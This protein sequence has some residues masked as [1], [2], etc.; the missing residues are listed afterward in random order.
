MIPKHYFRC[1]TICFLLI[2]VIL[3]YFLLDRFPTIS[4][5]IITHDFLFYYFIFNIIIVSILFFMSH[6]LSDSTNIVH[7]LLFPSVLIIIL[8][9]CKRYKWIHYFGVLSYVFCILYLIYN[10]HPPI[11]FL[12]FLFLPLISF[13]CLGLFEIL[14]LITVAVLL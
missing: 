1:Y 7:Y 9:D 14:S 2:F 3:I 10:N 8:F 6:C 5:A 13:G 12:I 11:I 4:E